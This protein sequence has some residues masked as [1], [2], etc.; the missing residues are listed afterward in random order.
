MIVPSISSL[1]LTVATAAGAVAA[2]AE[3]NSTSKL[4]TGGTVIAY[5]ATGQSL[6]VVRNGSVLIVDDTIEAVYSG[7]YDGQLP[8]HVE[9]VDTTGDI[10]T[11]GFIDTHRHSW[12]TAF[13]TLGSN[14][15]LA[16]Y[17][18]RYS[19]YS[20]NGEYTPEDVYIS[21]LAGL[22]EAM[23]AGVTT[24]LDHAHH[25]WSNETTDAGLQASIDSGVRMAWCFTFHNVTNFTFAEQVAKF[26][27]VARSG[28]L[29]GTATTLGIAYDGFNP[30][31]PSETEEI[32]SL[33]QKYN[34]SAI[35]THSLQGIWGAINSPED[36]QAL[37]ILN[38]SIPVVFSHGSFLTGEGASLLRSTNQYLSITPE[39]EMHY[40]HDHPYNHLVQDQA[41]LGVD[42]HFTYSS[43]ILTQ[44]R[45]WLQSARVTFYRWVL[46][47]WNIPANNPMSVNQA[48]LLAT[49]RGGLALRRPDL[50]VI[51][52][53]AKADVLVWNGNSP[54]MLGW[55][56]PVAAVVLHANAGDIKHVLVGGSFQKRDGA[57]VASG[58]PALRE[59]FLTTAKKIQA[60]WKKK[61][62]PVLEGEFPESGYEYGRVPLAD[63]QRGEGTGYGEQYL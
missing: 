26:E 42:T 19:E 39:S 21:Q 4:L 14:T 9:V 47:N 25:T 7:N 20:V 58:Y 10:I 31:S 35:T 8:S 51:A 27:E 16:E 11:P 12:Q 43:D 29:D 49:Q 2:A 56:D 28:R 15:T 45:I 41:A 18:D 23:N 57:I 38:T 48:F 50:G 36:L 59:R 37:G 61:A 17:F 6:Q 60:I 22:Y 34:V 53:G 1:A 44:A 32:I 52:Q 13:K 33:A 5:D 55:D 24:I 62:L 46:N 40:G 63:V 54:G 3:A 30:G